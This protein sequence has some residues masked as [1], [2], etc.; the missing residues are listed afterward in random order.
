VHLHVSDLTLRRAPVV[1]YLAHLIVEKA[2]ET[3]I[4]ME[5]LEGCSPDP[6]SRSRNPS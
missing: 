3:S 1:A 6:R 4:T 5:D 2:H